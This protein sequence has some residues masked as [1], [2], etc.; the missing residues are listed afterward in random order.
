MNLSYG[1]VPRISGTYQI[2]WS[3][4]QLLRNVSN[5]SP[6]ARHEFGKELWKRTSIDCASE[7]LYSPS[8]LHTSLG[9]GPEAVNGIK[10]LELIVSSEYQSAGDDN[11][12]LDFTVTKTFHDIAKSLKLEKLILQLDL[13]ELLYRK[14]AA[15]KLPWVSIFRTFNVAR[16]FEVKT[17]IFT[18]GEEADYDSYY[19]EDDYREEI[20]AELGQQVEDFLMPNTLRNKP[21][22]ES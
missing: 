2:D 18:S 20:V 14:L 11:F 12:E 19:G 16:S 8:V 17:L 21:A 4:I 22:L 6:H 7:E 1:S 15:G 5:V 13:T 10:C 9:D 3:M